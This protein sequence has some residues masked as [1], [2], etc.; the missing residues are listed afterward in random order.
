[1]PI[2]RLVG[3]PKTTDILVSI[4]R[5]PLVLADVRSALPRLTKELR[6]KWGV[7]SFTIESRQPRLRNPADPSQIVVQGVYVC[8]VI[9]LLGPTV[10]VAGKELSKH[11]RRWLKKFDRTKKR[12]KS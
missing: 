9:R 3:G 5:V 12:T 7:E 10:D 2:V 6:T 8:L 4:E 1:M 11:V